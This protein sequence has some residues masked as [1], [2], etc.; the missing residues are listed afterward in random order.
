V[1][2]HAVP[3]PGP[4]RTGTVT[5]AGQTITIIQAGGAACYLQLEGYTAYYPT[6][7]GSGKDPVAV[8]SGQC[9]AWTAA[10]DASWI[11]IVSGASSGPLTTG[12][13]TD[14][15]ISY[16]VALNSGAARTGHINVS[17]SGGNFLAT[18]TIN[19]AGTGGTPVCSFM[20]PA[21]TANVAA[22]GGTGSFG[23]MASDPSCAVTASPNSAF[24]H[25]TQVTPAMGSATVSYSVDQN[26]GPARMGTI[27]AGGQTF[28]VSQAA[29]TPSGTPV[30]FGDIAGK[31]GPQSTRVWTFTVGNSGTGTASAAQ[32]TGIEF[33]QTFLGG[34]TA[35]TPRITSPQA[36][37][38][39]LG[40]VAAGSTAQGGITI[41]FTGCANA[42]RFTVTVGLSANAGAATG[43]I[44]RNDEER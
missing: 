16:T 22:G 29:G 41:D 7:G 30:L 31:S 27:T 25:V 19:Q 3:N 24:L 12:N 36:F 42:A 2:F 26:T 5:I 10:P 40:D 39:A 43:S 44:L 11:N 15:T 4:T 34:G 23:V 14:Q 35:C 13:D 37:P 6:T 21:S 33:T 20:L 38:L 18:L 28:T 32:I 9:I 1:Y 8:A 17:D